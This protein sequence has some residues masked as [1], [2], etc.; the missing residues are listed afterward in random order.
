MT[1]LLSFSED[2]SPRRDE[3]GMQIRRFL[4]SRFNS[5]H[6]V[7]RGKK[8]GGGGR[9]VKKGRVHEELP[10]APCHVT[11]VEVEPVDNSVSNGRLQ[12]RH[13]SVVERREP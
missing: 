12:W 13:R 5:W 11:P 1:P 7:V 3:I 10:S 9:V 8:K 2:C 4:S 6:C